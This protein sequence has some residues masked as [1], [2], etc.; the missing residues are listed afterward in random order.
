METWKVFMNRHTGQQYAAYTIRGETTDEEQAT[1]ER[2]A[3]DY[4]LD[5]ADIITAETERG[6]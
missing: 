5:P 3:A 1:R 2:L 4:N 6:E